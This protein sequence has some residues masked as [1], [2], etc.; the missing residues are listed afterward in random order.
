MTRVEEKKMFALKQAVATLT[1]LDEMAR[2]TLLFLLDAS[3][4]LSCSVAVIIPA[5]RKQL[6]HELRHGLLRLNQHPLSLQLLLQLIDVPG[7]ILVIEGQYK[8]SMHGM[9]IDNK[10]DG[11]YSLCFLRDNKPPQAHYPFDAGLEQKLFDLTL[12]QAAA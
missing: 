10:Y 9:C 4:G 7:N 12:N 8:A 11:V 3:I 1:E 2:K 6:S 5:T